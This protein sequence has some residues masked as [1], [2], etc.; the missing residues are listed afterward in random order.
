MVSRVCQNP[1]LWPGG[2]LV[3]RFA[4]AGFCNSLCPEGYESAGGALV[5][6]C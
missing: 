5:T 6:L 3:L 1:H 4:P 2:S